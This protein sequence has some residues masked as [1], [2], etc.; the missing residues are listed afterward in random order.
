M[1]IFN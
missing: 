1:T